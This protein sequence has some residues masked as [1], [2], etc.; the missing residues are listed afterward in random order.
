VIQVT[1]QNIPANA[2]TWNVYAG[3][4]TE[5]LTL[6]NAMPLDPPQVWVEPNTGLVTGRSPGSGQDPN[7][8]R[9]LPRTLQRG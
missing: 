8:Y 5:S 1:P 9:I 6:Q 2:T 7:S 3:L 4:G